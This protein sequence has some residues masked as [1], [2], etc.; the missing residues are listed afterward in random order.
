LPDTH[1]PEGPLLVPQLPEQSLLEADREGK[2]FKIMP[3]S[4]HGNCIS[5]IEQL[6]WMGQKKNKK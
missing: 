6:N 5:R 2:R 4:K 3:P 1:N